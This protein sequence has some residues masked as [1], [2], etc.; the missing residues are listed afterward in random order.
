MP[1]G[2]IP[3]LAGNT[4]CGS[5]G[6]CSRGDHPRS[7]G[8]YQPHRTAPSLISGSS[9]LSRGIPAM[10]RSL[11]FT[12]RIIPAL[13]GNTTG[14]LARSVRKQDHPRSRGEYL[15]VF[16]LSSPARG[17]SPLS[18]GILAYVK[19]TVVHAGIIPALAGNTRNVSGKRC[20]TT[21]H[22][23]SRGEYRGR[24]I[25]HTVTGGSSPL[26]RGI[27]V[28]P[29]CLWCPGGIIPALAGNTRGSR[30]ASTT[31][32]DHPRSRGEYVSVGL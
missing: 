6:R 30:V 3:A 4:C 13:A 9:P 12:L 28:S 2:I 25:V 15:G 7:R 23:R 18:R 27:R 32:R 17:S 16:R 14:G 21:D 20:G 19:H 1:S 5:A 26:S 8:E 22:P 31:S 29:I 24:E 11:L 10:G